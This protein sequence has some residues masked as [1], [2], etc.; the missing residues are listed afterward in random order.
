MSERID[1]PDSENCNDDTHRY[2]VKASG[3]DGERLLVCSDCG[4]EVFDD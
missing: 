4:H 2:Q 3:P 1:P